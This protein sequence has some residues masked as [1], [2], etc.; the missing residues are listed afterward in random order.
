MQLDGPVGTRKDCWMVCAGEFAPSTGCTV[1]QH[2]RFAPKF[3]VLPTCGIFWSSDQVKV[4]SACHQM[5]LACSL[6]AVAPESLTANTP[7]GST[8]FFWGEWLLR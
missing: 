7:C 4:A 5:W 1:L 8:L 3:D 2:K 6:S